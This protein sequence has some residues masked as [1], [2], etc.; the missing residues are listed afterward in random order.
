MI[1]YGKNCIV[2]DSHIKR[3]RK[4]IFNNSIANG[5]AY[6]KSW[7]EAKVRHLD[8]FLELTWPLREKSP[9]MAKYRPEKLR[10]WTLF[11]Q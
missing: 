7:S 1:R 3:I 4:N 6:L 9:N 8:H 5:N 11:A 10:I 2:G